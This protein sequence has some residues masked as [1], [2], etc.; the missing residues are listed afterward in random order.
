M[1]EMKGINQVDSSSHDR[2]RTKIPL[3]TEKGGSSKSQK[4]ERSPEYI[5]HLRDRKT[6]L[7]EKKTD[8]QKE[9]GD[10]WKAAGGWV[11]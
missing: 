5:N 4:G 6:Q 3:N 11:V 2:G 1:D 10:E 9:N 7:R 8:D